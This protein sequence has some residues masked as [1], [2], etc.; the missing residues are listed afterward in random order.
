MMDY[1]DRDADYERRKAA[2]ELHSNPFAGLMDFLTAPA[3]AGMNKAPHPMDWAGTPF[4]NATN[5]AVQNLNSPESLYRQ[6]DTSPPSV[7]PSSF[8]G[9]NPLVDDIYKGI[10]E[11]IQTQADLAKAKT[12]NPDESEAEG[13]VRVAALNDAEQDPAGSPTVREVV[14]KNPNASV[15]E[16]TAA[17]SVD[18][19]A[20]TTDAMKKSGKWTKGWQE[21]WDKFTDTVDLFTFGTA[22]LATNDGSRSIGQNIGI[23]L[24][25]G[26][27]AKEAQ[28]DKARAIANE[29]WE[30]R[31]E[32]A[33]AKL[34]ERKVADAEKRTGVME[35]GLQID[36]ANAF[37][38]AMEA[39]TA[40]RNAASG[41][42]FKPKATTPATERYGLTALGK[43]GI[44]LDQFPEEDRKEIREQ[45]GSLIATSIQYS[46]T[47]TAADYEREADQAVRT[48]LEGYD[49]RTSFWGLGRDKYKPLGD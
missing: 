48:V 11:D 44:K 32:E 38:R 10:Q 23:A 15:G 6:P 41:T 17:R 18:I 31:Q 4:Q 13:T 34:E 7:T 29:E 24:Q 45:L 47:K 40:A 26:K 21:S 14:G 5:A 25:A 49:R 20:S 27:D 1:L 46:P 28:A 36:W 3:P 39:E 30:Q 43:A 8:P 37:T 33:K 22:L 35:E 9:D 12:P 42:D 2:G 16:V 19:A